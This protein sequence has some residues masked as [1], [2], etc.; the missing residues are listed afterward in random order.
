MTNSIWQATIQNDAGD[1]IP[2]AEITVVDENTGLNATIYSS[3]GGAALA[4]PF[5][6]NSNGFAQ[7]YAPSGTYRVTA[8]NTGTGETQTWR[9]IDLGDAASR[10]VG[11]TSGNVMEVGAFGLGADTPEALT[12]LS[13]VNAALKNGASYG[14]SGV[15]VGGIVGVL[16][17][18]LKVYARSPTRT[19]QEVSPDSNNHY[20]RFSDDGGAS[21]SD[22]QEFYH[23]GNLN[24]N[25]FGGA[26]ANR[27]IRN[28]YA[29]TATTA[30]F[31]LET[32]FDST[33]SSITVNGTFNI[34]KPGSVLVASAVTPVLIVGCAKSCLIEVSGL[35]GLSPG[36]IL[37]IR[38]NTASSTITVNP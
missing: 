9:Y 35:S 7:F 25:V 1:I 3:R 4:N 21:W 6:A 18:V 34:Y 36:E 12:T 38:T 31:L 16:Y 11:T 13:Q 10:D 5:F 29:N 19:H 32:L 17:G 14:V 27:I 26:S 28:G 30:F 22:W 20:A 33:P 24:P 23:S 8:E 2:G 15:D 37:Q